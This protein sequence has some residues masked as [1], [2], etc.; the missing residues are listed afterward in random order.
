MKKLDR[1]QLSGKYKKLALNRETVK[2]LTLR[3]RVAGGMRAPTN[4]DYGPSPTWGCQ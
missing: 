2:D 4:R 3:T 1:K